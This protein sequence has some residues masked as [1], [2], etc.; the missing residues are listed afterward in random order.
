MSIDF[1]PFTPDKEE[2]WDRFCAQSDTAWFRHTRSFIEYT[3]ACK[4][5][6]NSR[7]HSFFVYQDNHLVAIVPLV[8]QTVYGN[9]DKY[10]FALYDTNMVFPAF[11]GNLGSQNYKNL[12]KLIF[13][14]IDEIAQKN[15]IV[16]SRFFL[17]PLNPLSLSGKQRFNPFLRY[18]YSDKSITTNIISLEYSA[19]ELLGRVRKGHKADI[20]SAQKGKY[21]VQIYYRENA[22]KTAFD[23]Y[24]DIHFRDAGRKTRP[25][26]SW[27][28]MYEFIEKGLGQLSLVTDLETNLNITGAL[29]FTYKNAAYY[30][31]AATLPEFAHMRGIGHLLQWET[32]L[33]L[34]K[35]GIQYY[36]L[37]WNHFPVISQEIGKEKDLGISRYKSG[38][39]SD[40]YALFRGDRYFNKDFLI[41]K[42]NNLL[43]EYIATWMGKE[44]ENIPE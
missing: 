31:S 44:T 22:L 11:L 43:Q 16:R 29:L 26:S 32:M 5:D 14:Y 25:D 19:E 35:N 24:R 17:D 36:E 27:N 12:C 3:L 21:I 38:F 8:S 28:K 9:E 37:G 15:N 40:E 30:A 20:K 1:S 4:F 39:G 6:G 10:E 41:E 18:G 33:F 7:E 42:T 34:K 23:I 13:Q 2:E